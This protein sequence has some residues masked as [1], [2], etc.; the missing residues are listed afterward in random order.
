MNVLNVK[1]VFSLIL[2]NNV[3]KFNQMYVEI[4]H[5]FLLKMFTLIILNRLIYFYK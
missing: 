5:K 3:N 2:L 1:V 4:I